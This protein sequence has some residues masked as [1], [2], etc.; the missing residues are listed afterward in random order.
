MVIL[1]SL[2]ATRDLLEK[3]SIKYS[4]RPKSIVGGE[5]IGYEKTLPML[6]YNEKMKQIRRM[7]TKAVGTR[8][9]LEDFMPL[10][11]RTVQDYVLNLVTTPEKFVEHIRL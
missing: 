8:A 2:G 7:F 6:S 3:E 11:S 4:N 1:G 9:L 5:I 10:M